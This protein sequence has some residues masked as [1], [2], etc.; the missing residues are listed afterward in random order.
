MGLP[1]W[2]SMCLAHATLRRCS[3][4]RRQPAPVGLM[5]PIVLMAPKAIQ[6]SGLLNPSSSKRQEAW[7][8]HALCLAPIGEERWNTRENSTSA[9]RWQRWQ[10]WQRCVSVTGLSAH[11]YIEAHFI[12][13]HFESVVI[14]FWSACPMGCSISPKGVLRWVNPSIKVACS[15]LAWVFLSLICHLKLSNSVLASSTLFS[16]SSFQGRESD[17]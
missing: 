13:L 1:K 8:L 4:L 11:L 17:L 2:P 6:A 12:T 9:C 15:V 16:R 3:R 10:R 5:A 14:Y 7:Q